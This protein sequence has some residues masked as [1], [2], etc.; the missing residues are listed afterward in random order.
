MA[1]VAKSINLVEDANGSPKVEKEVI[2]K[3]H[4]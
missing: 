2:Q 1:I 3:M 4:S